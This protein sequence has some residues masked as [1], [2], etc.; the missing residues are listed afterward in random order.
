MK[1]KVCGL[2]QPEN[3]TEVLG[4]GID[5]AGFIFHKRS[6][7][8]A[9]SAELMRWMENNPQPFESTAKVGVFVNAEL[10]YIL[11]VVH[12]YQLDY[13][14]LHG[15]ESPGYCREL[16]LLWSVSTLR[17]AKI[18]KA[19]SVAADFN[20]R[21]TGE[22]VDSCPL[23]VFDTGGHPEAGGTG[24]KWDWERLAAYQHPVPFLL[25]GGIGPEDAAAVRA[26]QHPQLAGVDVNSRFESAPGVKDVSQLAAFVE[27]LR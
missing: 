18:I 6:P 20:F 27:A 10:D 22:Y 23:F 1:I 3:I 25:S 4:L 17:K 5:F 24:Q 16:K 13:V 2:R 15:N 9:A 21:D 11:N 7:R 26:L 12:D 8:H 19:F 14:Q